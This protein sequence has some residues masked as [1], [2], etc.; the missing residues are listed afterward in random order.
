MLEGVG[1]GRECGGEGAEEGEAVATRGAVEDEDAGGPAFVLAF[2]DTERRKT[3]RRAITSAPNQS[4]QHCRLSTVC[5]PSRYHV[6]AVLVASFAIWHRPGQLVA[7]SPCTIFSPSSSGAITSSGSSGIPS[8]VESGDGNEIAF[9]A[10]A[11]G[12]RGEERKA[13][14]R[15]MAR[16]A[17]VRW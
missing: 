11:G 17:F 7:L 13:W 6:S 16:E 12:R 15:A 10:K 1:E 8:S 9:A 2:V 5:A 4:P 3:Y 14:T